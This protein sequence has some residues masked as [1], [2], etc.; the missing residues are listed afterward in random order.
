VKIIFSYSF[1]PEL[2]GLAALFWRNTSFWEG[3]K[4]NC[5]TLVKRRLWLKQHGAG[6]A[7]CATRQTQDKLLK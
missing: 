7:L 1:R 4:I 3:D 2:I 6:V 5:L